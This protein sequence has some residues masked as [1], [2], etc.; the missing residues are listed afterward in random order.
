MIQYDQLVIKLTFTQTPRYLIDQ[1]S[2]VITP[3]T[4]YVIKTYSSFD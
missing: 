4:D 2:F 3:N 1:P